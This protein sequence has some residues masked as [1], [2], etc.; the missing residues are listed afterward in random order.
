MQ[1]A[2]EKAMTRLQRQTVTRA[3]M[4][5]SH[6][7]KCDPAA[8]CDSESHN[9]SSSSPPPSWAIMSFCLVAPHLGSHRAWPWSPHPCPLL[10]ASLLIKR[11]WNWVYF[12]NCCNETA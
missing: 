2:K 7:Q 3:L 6:L 11:M 1:V 5:P 4:C 8:L 10:L 9:I 12:S